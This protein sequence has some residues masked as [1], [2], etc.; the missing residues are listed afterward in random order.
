MGALNCRVEDVKAFEA[1]RQK[2]ILSSAVSSVRGA[3]RDSS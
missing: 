2:K 1:L 3:C